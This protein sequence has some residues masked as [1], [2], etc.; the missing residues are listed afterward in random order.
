[1][2][3]KALLIVHGIGEQK[4]GET[5]EKLICGL[6]A[7]FGGELQVTRADD[8]NASDIIARGTSVRIHEVYWADLLSREANRGTFKW[9]TLPTLV[10]HPLLCRR[11]GLLPRAEYPAGLVAAWLTVLLPGSLLGYPMAQGAR[12][13]AQ[14]FDDKRRERLR[15]A[16]KD[17]GF[18]ERARATADAAA[19]DETVVE[20]TLE[21]V[22]A[23]VPNYMHSIARGEGV[24]LE[25]L[26][27]FHGAMRA[28][29]GQGCDEV[30]VLSHSLGTVVAYHALTGLGQPVGE[31]PHAPKRLYTI[32]SPLE[33]IRFFWP[34]TVK[35]AAPSAHPEFQ[36]TNFY[37]RQDAVSG[38]LRRFEAWAPLTNIR[39]KGGGGMLRSHVVYEKS[40][41][42]LGL[43][44]KDLFGASASPNLTTAA[45][46]KDRIL[47]ALENLL[48]PVA[49]IA[50]TLLGLAAVLMVLLFPGYLISLPF[51]WLGA[52]QW[53][54]RIGNGISL[55]MV[56]G[57]LVWLIMELRSYYLE[58]RKTVTEAAQRASSSPSA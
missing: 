24:A 23:D 22:V 14:I 6:H 51:R 20:E 44:T 13:Y 40:P 45:L 42:F 43:L 54:F 28:A 34:W 48:G 4:R 7:A 3:R 57:M 46:L 38:R 32:G 55:F 21:G 50:S 8:G 27:R 11:A 29:R 10:W 12:V 53:G 30:H 37:H 15:A 16:S 18:F 26:A 39:L 25:V 36:W 49:V 31:A 35:A 9:S 5:T 2:T 56:G 33:K 19:H 41:Q 1:M 52:E 47:T 17:V 58:A